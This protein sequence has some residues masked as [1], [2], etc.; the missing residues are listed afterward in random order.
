MMNAMKKLISAALALAL[1]LGALSGCSAFAPKGAT[2]YATSGAANTSSSAPGSGGYY[3]Y[4]D[5]NTPPYYYYQPDNEEYA[6][7]TEGGFYSTLARPLS[8]FAADV[9]TASYCNLRRM[10]KEGDNIGTIPADA[11]RIEE[12][13]NYFDY[14][15]ASPSNGELF[16][17]TS[18]VA[19]CPWNPDTK[20]LI[21]GFSTNSIDYSQ[22][23]GSNYVFLIDVSGSMSDQDK[24][25]LLQKSFKKL[26]QQLDA[27]DRVSIVTYAGEERLVCEGVSG[28]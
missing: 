20:L 3:D 23:A 11:V 26:I 9:D 4:Y 8:T 22:I 18:Q 24:L 1:C 7:I 21:M 13:L 16:G 19:D 12:M 27:S 6:P 5:Y 14:D 25:P 17:L 2:D 15:Y 10:I 28:A